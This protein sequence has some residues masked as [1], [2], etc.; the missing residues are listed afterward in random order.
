MKKIFLFIST[1]A[2]MLVSS[3]AEEQNTDYNRTYV[4][5]S[6]DWDLHVTA[7]DGFTDSVIRHPNRAVTMTWS[8]MVYDSVLKQTVINSQV[9][10]GNG[11]WRLKSYVSGTTPGKYSMM[12]SSSATYTYTTKPGMDDSLTIINYKLTGSL[13]WLLGTDITLSDLEIDA[14]A[15][16]EDGKKVKFVGTVES[17]NK[18]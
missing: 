1:V 17:H 18:K 13:N 10:I 15:T 5:V 3:C 8:D 12:D 16:S 11:V 14:M 7:W 2:A 4:T 6:G 9:T